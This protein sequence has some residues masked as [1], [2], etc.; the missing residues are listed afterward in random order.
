MQRS[1]RGK[2]D[3]DCIGWTRAGREE[4]EDQADPC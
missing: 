2:A 3:S 4:V 1:S